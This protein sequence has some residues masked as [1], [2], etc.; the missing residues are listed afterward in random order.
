VVYGAVYGAPGSES[1]FNA[2]VYAIGH[3]YQAAVGSGYHRV[4]VG[5][6]IAMMLGAPGFVLVE[7]DGL[8]VSLKA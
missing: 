3:E 7:S 8:A 1:G 4:D 2:P 6:G 5:Y